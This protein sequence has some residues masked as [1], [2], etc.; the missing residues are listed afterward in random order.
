MPSDQDKA[1]N[2]FHAIKAIHAEIIQGLNIEDN[3]KD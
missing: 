1:D 3:L 2:I